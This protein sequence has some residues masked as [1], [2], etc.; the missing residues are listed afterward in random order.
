MN[1]G[2]YI[3]VATSQTLKLSDTM[4]TSERLN[5]YKINSRR[6]WF[7]PK[8]EEASNNARGISRR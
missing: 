3:I 6:D 8:I 4:M 5:A 1:E 7:S 2:G